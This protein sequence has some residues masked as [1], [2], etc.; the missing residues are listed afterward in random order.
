MF[1]TVHQST[2]NMTSIHWPFAILNKGYVSILS[3]MEHMDIYSSNVWTFNTEGKKASNLL[4]W[5]WVSTTWR[6]T[7]EMRITKQNVGRE[8]EQ[9]SNNWLVCVT[10]WG[11]HYVS[12][13]MEHW[14]NWQS[15]IRQD[16]KEENGAA[17]FLHAVLPYNSRS[18]QSTQGFTTLREEDLKI[19]A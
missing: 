7:Q 15:W 10:T 19:Y 11:V 4:C 9:A 12:L 8:V 13:Q 17:G 6:K 14:G 16:K 5:S 2:R 18:R 1:L 3:H